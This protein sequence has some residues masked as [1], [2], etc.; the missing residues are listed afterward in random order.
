MIWLGE[1]IS[2]NSKILSNE[3]RSEMLSPYVKFDSKQFYFLT[4]SKWA[5]ASVLLL[6]YQACRTGTVL[7][8][9]AIL[10]SD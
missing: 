5:L 3:L 1:L 9:N 2:E 7:S 4:F 8:E 6:N 10:L